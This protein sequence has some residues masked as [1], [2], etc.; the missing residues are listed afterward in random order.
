M[1]SDGC[2]RSRIWCSPERGYLV[3]DDW[4]DDWGDSWDDGSDADEATADAAIVAA[5]K[6]AS[7]RPLS[8]DER[9]DSRVAMMVASAAL[10]LS[11]LLPIFVLFE[12]ETPGGTGN[13]GDVWGN[14]IN[15]PAIGAAALLVGLPSFIAS[16]LATGKNAERN[17]TVV[18]AIGAAT[19]LIVFV[20]LALF[21]A[22]LATTPWPLLSKIAH[23][24]GFRLEIGPGGWAAALSA[25]ALMVS[26][27][28]TVPAERIQKFHA[29]W[30]VTR[31]LMTWKAAAAI[32]VAAVAVSFMRILPW[33]SMDGIVD[34]VLP[35]VGHYVR[36]GGA[37][38]SAGFIPVVGGLQFAGI[39]F[40]ALGAI[41]GFLRRG[42]YGTL[43]AVAG[44]WLSVGAAGIMGSL[45]FD[46]PDLSLA[47]QDLLG[48]HVNRINTSFSA[49]TPAVVVTLL[50]GIA[51]LVI[52]M[53]GLAKRADVIE[54]LPALEGVD[55]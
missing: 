14:A 15:Y 30:L 24:S 53:D 13:L 18:F 48:V 31:G 12:P 25:T 41:V 23:G 34:V 10:V 3:T 16:Y 47:R 20:P 26:A 36:N 22:L 11:S 9:A 43:F 29:S 35:K 42:V 40:L 45:T 33:V 4:D 17:S 7:S 49:V 2:W 32:A 46:A 5:D 28:R 21:S 55:A 38:I 39:G 44:G 27:A 51:A 19:F 54:A 1:L 50:V 52:G 8:A 6:A 37:S